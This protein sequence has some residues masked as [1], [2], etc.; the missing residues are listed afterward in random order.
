MLG[1]GVVNLPNNFDFNQEDMTMKEIS[2]SQKFPF[3]GKRGLSEEVAA[4][5]A[6]AGAAEVTTSPTRWSGTSKR[7]STI[8]PMSIELWK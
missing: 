3:P 5:E 7:P 1:F 2:V 8:F 4:K 6:E